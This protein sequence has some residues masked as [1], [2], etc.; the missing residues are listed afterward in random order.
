[1]ARND[2]KENLIKNMSETGNLDVEITSKNL[3][4]SPHLQEQLRFIGEQLKPGGF[5]HAGSV[6]IHYYISN[7]SREAAFVHQTVGLEGVTAAVASFGLSD[8][9]LKLRQ[10]FDP[11]FKQ[12]TR[13][14]LDKR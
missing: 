6:T 7:L 3:P 10:Q 2:G 9:S 5:S 1:M 12:K 13:N 8:A 11:N 4:N 14:K